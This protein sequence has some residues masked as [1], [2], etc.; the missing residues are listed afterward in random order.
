MAKEEADKKLCN[1]PPMKQRSDIRPNTRSLYIF[2]PKETENTN[3]AQL[4]RVSPPFLDANAWKPDPDEQTPNGKPFL[5]PT[6]GRRTPRT[7]PNH[8]RLWTTATKTLRAHC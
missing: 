8:R 6:R 1:P 4:D 7:Y 2:T 5:E 3:R